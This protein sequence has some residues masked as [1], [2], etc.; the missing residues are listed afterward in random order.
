[1]E[2]RNSVGMGQETFLKKNLKI[3]ENIITIKWLEMV[4]FNFEPLKG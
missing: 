3:F 4:I 2:R 1:M